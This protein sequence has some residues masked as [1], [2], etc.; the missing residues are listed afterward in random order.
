MING[1]QVKICGLTSLDDAL[2]ADKIGADYFGFILWPQSPRHVSL[3][4]FGAIA[5]KLPG[6]KKVAVL[7]EPSMPEVLQAKAAGFDRVQIH[8]RHATPLAR[9]R[10]WSDA[11]GAKKLWLAPKL[12][13][14]IDFA[15]EWLPLADAFLLDA[16]DANAA[17]F[18]GTGQTGD[19]EKFARHRAAHPDNLWILAGG[20]SPENIAEAVEKTGAHF[21][22]VNSAVETSPGV[23]D[24]AKLQQLMRALRQR[25]KK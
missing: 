22:D 8:F 11:V 17:Q 9:V 13:P 10:E 1:I 14:E 20:L 24:H 3:E 2:A 21:V 19:W 12:P 15:P 18:G 16:F 6:R 7:V 5:A 4:S 23:K 25:Q